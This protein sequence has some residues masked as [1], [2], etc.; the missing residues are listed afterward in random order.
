M[1]NEMLRIAL[2]VIIFSVFGFRGRCGRLGQIP[3]YLM[4]A[5]TIILDIEDLIS[6]RRS[7]RLPGSMF[8]GRNISGAY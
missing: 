5:K 1:K 6:A 7:S 8:G 2:N 4:V 3:K